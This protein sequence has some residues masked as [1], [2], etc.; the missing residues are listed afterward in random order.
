MLR[1]P[2]NSSQIITPDCLLTSKKEA[3]MS[4]EVTGFAK[5]IGAIDIRQE[6][7]DTEFKSIF[8]DPN[9]FFLKDQKTFLIIK[10]SRSYLKNFWGVGKKFVEIFN[11][12]TDGKLRYHVVCLTSD[13]SGWV[14]TGT[15]LN[16]CIDDG[17]LSYSSK[18]HQYIINEYNLK[19]QFRF[20]TVSDCLAII[21]T[22]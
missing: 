14:I 19:D 10:I 9:Y 8:R 15:Y 3:A 5:L 20:R 4:I 13:S 21:E 22:S 12:I 17:T 16:A 1:L 2:A 7:M 18:G 6:L 11:T